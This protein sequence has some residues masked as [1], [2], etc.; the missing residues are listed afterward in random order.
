MIWL[1]FL[2]SA[3]AGNVI[4][5]N[6][7][8]VEVRIEQRTMMKLLYPS[9]ARF[10]YAAGPTQLT[11]LV[12]GEP[13][14]I[15]IQIPEDGDVRVVVGRNGISHTTDAKPTVAQKETAVTFRA[16]GV[17]PIQLRLGNKR[18]VVTPDEEFSTTLQSGRHPVEI[19]NLEG[20]LL[21]AAGQL[22]LSGLENV[23]V[24]LIEGRMPEVVGKGSQFYVRGR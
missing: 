5:D 9:Q 17:E 1:L 2:A 22:E 11:L 6:E 21:W 24:Q 18:H 7:V 4:I 20:T 16:L 13:K 15:A 8:P 3:L 14:N 12:N 19:R 23:V 10:E